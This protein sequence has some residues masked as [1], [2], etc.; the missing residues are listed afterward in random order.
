MEIPDTLGMLDAATPHWFG[1][2]T[3]YGEDAWGTTSE[4][5][6]SAGNSDGVLMAW[7]IPVS[8]RI[9]I[10]ALAVNVATA[11]DSGD[12]VQLGV[13]ASDG[14][15]NRPSTLLA[16]TGDVTIDT[17]GEKIGTFTAITLYPGLYWFAALADIAGATNPRFA[18]NNSPAATYY[19]EMDIGGNGSQSCTWDAGDILS[20][21]LPDPFDSSV[22][23]SRSG[24]FIFVQARVA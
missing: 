12:H 18:G 24:D 11:A 17:T 3:F 20:G 19:H 5:R 15:N 1:N 22:A 14:D 2:A 7:P 21:T 23:W 8:R 9:D 13:Y 10:D 6:A 16:T 4:F